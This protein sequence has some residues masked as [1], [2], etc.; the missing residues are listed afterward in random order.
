MC[1]WH[2]YHFLTLRGYRWYLKPFLVEDED[3]DSQ[4]YSL[5]RSGDKNSRDQKSC[6]DFVSKEYY[7]FSVSQEYTVNHN[8]INTLFCKSSTS[9]Y[10]YSFLLHCL[11]LAMLKILLGSCQSFIHI[12]KHLGHS[13][14]IITQLDNMTM[15]LLN[16]HLSD[17]SYQIPKLK[18]F[19][20]SLAVV[21]AQSIEA[22]C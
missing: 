19:L 21:F 10:V 18:C 17:N 6:I 7:V 1:R 14:A 22:R 8:E 20:S 11:F 3:L 13:V 4:Y 15:M 12:P 5:W 9:K 16:L 2:S